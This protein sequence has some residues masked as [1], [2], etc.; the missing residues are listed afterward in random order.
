M[1]SHT[2]VVRPSVL[3][4]LRIPCNLRKTVLGPNPAL[5]RFF[6]N[7]ALLIMHVMLQGYH[8]MAVFLTKQGT[9]LT[10]KRVISEPRE[11]LEEG[12]RELIKKLKG[13]DCNGAMTEQVQSLVSSCASVEDQVST[14]YE[15]AQ[16]WALPIPASMSA[17]LEK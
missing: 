15:I 13:L 8:E 11:E 9:L 6:L 5:S 2:K 14:A 12:L 7:C 4:T 16:S 10:R 3:C 1:H 17:L